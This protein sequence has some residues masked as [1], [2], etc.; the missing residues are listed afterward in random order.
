MTLKQFISRL[1]FYFNMFKTTE[2]CYLTTYYYDTE[3]V[4]WFTK[5]EFSR[6]SICDDWE[7]KEVGK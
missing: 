1:E 4:T 2:R 6:D 5:T 7:I 3:R